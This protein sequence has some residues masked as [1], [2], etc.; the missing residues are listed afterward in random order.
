MYLLLFFLCTK[1]ITNSYFN[2]SVTN[3][4]ILKQSFKLIKCT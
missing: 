1:I 3:E 2:Q 4:E